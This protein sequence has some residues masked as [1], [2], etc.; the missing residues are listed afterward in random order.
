MR[1]DRLASFRQHKDEFLKKDPDSPI[2]EAERETFFGLEYFPAN[3]A[4]AFEL[5]VDQGGKGSGEQVDMPCSDGVIKHYLR[6]GVVR[7]EVDS[8]PVTLTVLTDMERGRFFLPFIDATNGV[9]TYKGGRFLDP[10]RKPNGL[11]SVDFNYAYNPYCAY[12][13]GWS[14]PEPPPEN[15]LTVSIRA[16]EKGRINGFE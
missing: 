8:M 10:Q 16:G 11:L 9:E 15:R 1:S 6:Y 7:F 3:E 5:E 2:A 12:S 4:L 13:D 14:C